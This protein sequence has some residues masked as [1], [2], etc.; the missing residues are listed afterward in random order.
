MKQRVARKTLFPV[1]CLLIA[2]GVYG[3][4]GLSFQYWL[5][6]TTQPDIGKYNGS[7]HDLSGRTDSPSSSIYSGDTT[8]EGFFIGASSS[9]FYKWNGSGRFYQ[10]TSGDTPYSGTTYA[11][12]A[13]DTDVFIGAGSEFYS[14]DVA[15]ETFTNLQSDSGPSGTI[16]TVTG[17][18]GEKLDS[19]FLL[20]GTG[21]SRIWKWDGSWS[22]IT[23]GFIEAKV[24]GSGKNS[25]HLMMGDNKGNLG[26]YDGSSWTSIN[27]LTDFNESEH[28]VT[29]IEFGDFPGNGKPPFWLIAARGGHIE[30]LY[31]NGTN[32][33][34]T[35]DLPGSWEIYSAG[36][37]P[38]E[39]EFMVG[40]KN[41]NLYL[42]NSSG[43]FENQPG[44][45]SNTV[46]LI[47]YNPHKSGSGSRAGV[48]QG[49]KMSS[50]GTK[51][52]GFSSSQRQAA[53]LETLTGKESAYED[54]PIQ[55]LSLQQ[56]GS[57]SRSALKSLLQ[58]VAF[59]GAGGERAGLVDAASAKVSIP[60]SVNPAA[61]LRG[62][63]QQ[64]LIPGIRADKGYGTYGGVKQKV[65]TGGSLGDVFE[66]GN[67][68]N[69]QTD[70]LTGSATKAAYGASMAQ[71]IGLAVSPG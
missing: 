56:I 62:Y 1:L 71:Q 52:A 51:S 44:F 25:T 30:K 66:A 70:V 10:W 42:Y 29:A 50:E 48:S 16:Y 26:L 2:G 67:I 13:N 59:A 68:L 9:E 45:F 58:T 49:I 63:L 14:F 38:D 57:P 36:Y 21:Q 11:M 40:G 41:S 35:G 3:A 28:T 46:R 23:P 43:F 64:Q 7:W 69:Q 20:L 4:N 24:R 32:V 19:D 8:P 12:A 37:D 18:Y 31:V 65:S 53:V 47:S 34:L 6:G 33:D 54:F 39:G 27:S 55:K 60:G 15:N 61:A 5:A 22:D 17:S